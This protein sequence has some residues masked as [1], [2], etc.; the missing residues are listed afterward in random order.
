MPRQARL[1]AP[2]ALQHVIIKSIEGRKVVNNDQDR[3]EICKRT[4]AVS[5]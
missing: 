2:C 3:E 5:K 1:N 4:R